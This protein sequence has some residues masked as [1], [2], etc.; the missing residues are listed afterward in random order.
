M[1]VTSLTHSLIESYHEACRTIGDP[2]NPDH[3]FDPCHSLLC[4]MLLS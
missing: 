3:Q 1:P 2:L 4:L